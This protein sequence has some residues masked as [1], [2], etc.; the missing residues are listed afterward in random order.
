MGEKTGAQKTSANSS[1]AHDSDVAALG[2]EP[3]FLWP[4]IPCFELPPC[5][6]GVWG[7]YKAGLWSTG[8]KGSGNRPA[9]RNEAPAR[10]ANFHSESFPTVSLGVKIV[11]SCHTDSAGVIRL[12]GAVGLTPARGGQLSDWHVQLWSITE[13]PAFVQRQS[14]APPL[15]GA[16]AG[17]VAPLFPGPCVLLSAPPGWLRT[18]AAADGLTPGPLGALGS[19]LLGW[20]DIQ[21]SVRQEA[22]RVLGRPWLLDSHPPFMGDTA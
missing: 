2:F 8:V 17:G 13:T 9:G 22:T 1:R 20:A 4:Q 19:L 16:S 12:S 21:S 18:W 3:G 6:A 15:A 11:S 5:R 10:P 7:G 14:Y